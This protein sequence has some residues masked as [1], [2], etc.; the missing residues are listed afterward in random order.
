LRRVG[1]FVNSVES[2]PAKQ[3]ELAAFRARLEELGWSEGQN[4]RFDYRWTDGNFNMLREYAKELVGASPDVILATNAPTL[5]ALR[6]ETQSIPLV[7]AQIVDPVG[8][9]FVPSL[10]HPGGNITG[11][12]HFEHTIA[13]KWLQL[14]KEVTPNITHVA[15]IWNP[16]NITVN[17]FML[18]IKAAAVQFSVEPIEVHVQNAFE[19]EHTFAELAH[20]PNIGLIVPPDFTTVVNRSSII[21]SAA[22][23]N[24]PAIYPFR[25]FAVS[26]GLMSYGIN[27]RTMY[28]ET[29]SYIDRILRGEKP[30]DLP[31]Q[32]PTK[33]ELVINQKT[34]RALGL[35]IPDSLLST[36]DD[37][38]DE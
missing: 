12:T 19:I 7:F 15:V 2:D 23:Y 31:V 30:G 20:T 9:G 5:E 36:A 6:A 18:K 28:I 4:I 33:Y 29:A 17:G 34:A 25:L 24:M 11:F 14:L 38:L 21:T 32:A 13:G 26:G 22:R 35:E 37:L 27:L 16:N 10:S 8:N 3:S 1:V